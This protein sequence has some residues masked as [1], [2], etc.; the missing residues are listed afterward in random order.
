MDVKY[1]PETAEIVIMRDGKGSVVPIQEIMDALPDEVG[2]VQQLLWMID[3]VRRRKIE[4]IETYADK[5]IGLALE[6][7]KFRDRLNVIVTSGNYDALTIK[8]YDSLI[9]ACLT[10]KNTLN[11]FRHNTK[12]MAIEEG[13]LM[14]LMSD[15]EVS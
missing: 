4:H 6:E 12:L 13:R 7:K 5:I 10:E 2:R 15:L 3:A 14:K 9:K 1:L 11:E 8:A